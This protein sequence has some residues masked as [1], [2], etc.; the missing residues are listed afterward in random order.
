MYINIL[1]FLMGIILSSILYTIEVNA[2]QEDEEEEYYWM[3][4]EYSQSYD[5]EYF[6]DNAVKIN[7]I[8][9][10]IEENNRILYAQEVPRDKDLDRSTLSA[11][12]SKIGFVLPTFTMAAYGDK[13][14]YGHNAFYTFYKK[15]AQV[16][17]NEFVISDVDLLS[18]SLL[19][20]EES[21]DHKKNY[22]LHHLRDYTSLLLPNAELSYLTDQAIHDG[23]IFAQDNSNFYN[24]LVLGHLEYVTQ[25]E[26]NNFKRFVDNGGTLILF[27]ANT[28]YT[29]V[30]YDPI[31]NKISLVKG[32]SWS[33]DGER[34]MRDIKERWA[35]ENTEWVGSN[36]ACGSSCEITFNNNPFSYTHHEEQYIT[37]PTAKILIDYQAQSKYNFLIAAYELKYG[38]GKVVS[39]GIFGDDIFEENNL[40]SFYEDTIL[41]SI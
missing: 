10:M 36:F 39:F 13:E 38:F 27:D 20:S 30:E 29:E 8:N 41:S 32:H 35:D 25:Q 3:V 15:Y 37:N 23:L 16:K 24:I 7:I 6:K 18:Q 26:Y 17:E 34:A 11:S 40:L 31:T 28:F 2:Q 12:E 14:V 1:L 22:G 33:F 4:D 9:E 21:F 19:N 5:E